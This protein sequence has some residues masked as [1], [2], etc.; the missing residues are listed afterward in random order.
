[1]RKIK[2]RLKRDQVSIHGEIDYIIGRAQEH[3]SRVVQLGKFVF[4]STETGDA[5]MLDPEDSLAL[6]LSRDGEREVFKVLETPSSFQV[7]WNAQ[8]R[9]EG[10]I[11]IVLSQDGRTRSIVGY[12]TREIL[13]RTRV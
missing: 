10:N 7:S 8:Y 3:G 9:I 2:K 13:Q 12:P 6:C 1:M 4:F 11:F 5:W